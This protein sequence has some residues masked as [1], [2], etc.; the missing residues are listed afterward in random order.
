MLLT[1]ISSRQGCRVVKSTVIVIDMVS[2]QNVL[3]PFCCT[4]GKDTLQRFSLLGD[5][6]KQFEI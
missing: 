6:S 1:A 4:L 5:L 2:V 3:A